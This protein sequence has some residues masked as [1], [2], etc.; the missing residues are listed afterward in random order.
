LNQQPEAWDYLQRLV[1]DYPDA[2]QMDA[3]LYLGVQIAQ[4]LGHD[5][6]VRGWLQKLVTQHEESP[7][8]PD[9]ALRLAEQQVA[10][11]DVAVAKIL[12]ER[13][14]GNAEISRDL[15]TRA[16]FLLVR[17]AVTESDWDVVETRS[18]NILNDNPGEPIKTLARFWHAEAAY[19]HG[20]QEIAF[21][22]YLD[23]SLA[24]AGRKEAWLGVVPLR[25]GQ[26][27]AQRQ[28]WSTALEWANLAAKEYPQY[29]RMHEIDYVR[30]RSL[31]GLARFEE[32]RDLPHCCKLPS[33]A[34]SS[35]AGTRPLSVMRSCSATMATPAMSPM[36]DYASKKLKPN[37]PRRP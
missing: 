37:S 15:T 2:D 8:W 6:S 11:R 1:T 36:P 25:L 4:R 31:A 23:L 21:A 22:R 12:V 10:A 17:L 27:E 33:A 9:A 34:S 13:I 26:I 5:E 29:S 20:E 28:K 19:R 18:Q 7:Y 3:A 32:A 16:Q 24:I 35:A 14:L 30:G